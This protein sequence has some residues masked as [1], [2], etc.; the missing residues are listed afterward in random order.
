MIR[1][2]MLSMMAAV[3]MAVGAAPAAAQSRDAV[4]GLSGLP[5][6]RFVSLSAGVANMRA[7]PGDRYPVSWVYQRRGLPLK[8]VKEYGIWRQV[9]DP[10]GGEG[11]INKNLL[12]GARTAYVKGTTQ[13]LYAS[14]STDS[15]VVWRAEAG[16]IG[17]LSK[18]D[19]K[20]WCRLSVGGRIGFIHTDALWGT[21]PGEA[22]D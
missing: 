21:L 13:A 6:P 17:N 5:T 4:E 18:C 15:P 1:Q 16:V 9:E 8:I 3:A 11:W 14:R 2:A 12:S 19:G 7:G 20:G 22:F 10:D